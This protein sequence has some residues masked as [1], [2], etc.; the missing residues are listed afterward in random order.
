MKLVA[1]AQKLGWVGGLAIAVVS[2]IGVFRL[3]L[4]PRPWPR[5]LVSLL[6]FLVAA[7]GFGWAAF[8]AAVG[9]KRQWSDRWCYVVA[10]L[11]YML[12]GFLLGIEGGIW[13]A[14]VIANGAML[15]GILC[16]KIA[17]PQLRL[18]GPGPEPPISLHIT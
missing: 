16:R 5:S 8:W 4:I 6:L 12:V 7:M 14:V 11:S 15:V 17:Y 2:W 10:V 18:G 3:M 13:F 1:W 9:R